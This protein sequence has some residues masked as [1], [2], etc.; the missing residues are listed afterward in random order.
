MGP[1]LRIYARYAIGIV[2][3]ALVVKGIVP[4]E[5]ADIL[6][7]DATITALSSGFLAGSAFVVEFLYKKAKARGWSL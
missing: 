4:Q 7:Q 2:T 3:G 1:I 5:V 6:N